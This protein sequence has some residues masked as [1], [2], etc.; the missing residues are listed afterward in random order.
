MLSFSTYRSYAIYDY[1]FIAGQPIDKVDN[2]KYLGTICSSSLKWHENSDFING[3]P[4]S[5]FYAFFP[6]LSN[7]AKPVSER[8][9][10]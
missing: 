10:Y 3:K 9:F 4:R 2:F 6:N 5:R 8:P 7:S 1:F